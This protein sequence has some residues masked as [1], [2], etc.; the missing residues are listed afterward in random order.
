MAALIASTPAHTMNLRRPRRPWHALSR[1]SSEC[2]NRRQVRWR[3]SQCDRRRGL[4]AE[5]NQFDADHAVSP[6]KASLDRWP[7]AGYV[8]REPNT[9]V[10]R[11]PTDPDCAIGDSSAAECQLP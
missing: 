1:D 7:P 10:S 11:P 8:V 2:R 5:W 6:V 3:P 9:Q 4:E